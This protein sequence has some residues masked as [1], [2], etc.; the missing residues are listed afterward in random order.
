MHKVSYKS[1]NTDLHLI[2]STIALGK[3]KKELTLIN[4]SLIK[5]S[6]A[7]NSNADDA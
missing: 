6:S 3:T 7:I 4:E 2:I 5:S 1:L